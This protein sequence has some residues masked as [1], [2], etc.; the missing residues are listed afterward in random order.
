MSTEASVVRWFDSLPKGT[1]RDVEVCRFVRGDQGEVKHVHNVELEL[2]ETRVLNAT[3]FS[4]TTGPLTESA[5]L[6]AV[7]AGK[8]YRV[9]WTESEE[10]SSVHVG[11]RIQLPSSA[12]LEDTAEALLEEV[13]RHRSTPEELR[14]RISAY[15]ARGTP[16][17]R[18]T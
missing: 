12:P 6:L 15:F 1:R 7:Y 4:C 16:F 13:E 3:V 17:E 10:G 5:V 18:K 11:Y 2:R 8:L 14:R 9:D